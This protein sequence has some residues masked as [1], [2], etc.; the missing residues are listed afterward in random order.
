MLLCSAALTIAVPSLLVSQGFEWRS[1]GGSIGLRRDLLAGSR[2][3]TT[4][5]NIC[6]MYCTGF[7]SHNASLT[8]MEV[9]LLSSLYL[10]VQ[11][12]V[13]CGSMFTVI[14]L[15]H[16]PALLQ[17]RPVLF[18]WLVQQ[19]GMNF[20]CQSKA[21][22]NWCPF[23]FHH[24]LKTVLFRLAWTMTFWL[25]IAKNRST[26]TMIPFTNTV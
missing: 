24:L 6:G 23:S 1:W 9:W 17:C 20:Q 7:H 11:A 4:Y 10:L 25:N 16:L 21:S 5:P 22:P 14:W 12:I 13:H 26:K 18:L 3:L 2:S 19:R 8:G 15:S